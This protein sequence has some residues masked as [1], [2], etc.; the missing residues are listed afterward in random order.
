MKIREFQE[1]IRRIY[2]E[3]DKTRGR[4]KT[5]LWVVE[6]VGELAEAVRKD[7]V[8]NIGEEIADITAWIFSLANLYGIDVEK[9]IVKKYPGYCRRCGKEVCECQ[10]F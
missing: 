10:S 1:M 8:E 2:F 7:D 5:M 4:E 9:E 6:E 3:R